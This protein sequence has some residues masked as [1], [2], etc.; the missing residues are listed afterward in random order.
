MTIATC[1]EALN[2]ASDGSTAQRYGPDIRSVPQALPIFLDKLVP[3]VV[4]I[5]SAL[6]LAQTVQ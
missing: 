5:V 4:A 2:A 3:A 1:F 6:Y